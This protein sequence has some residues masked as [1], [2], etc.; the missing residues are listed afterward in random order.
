MPNLSLSSPPSPEFDCPPILF[1]AM[2]IVSCASG[3]I[4]PKLIAAD[5]NLLKIS[6]FGSTSEISIDFFPDFKSKKSRIYLSP[7][8]FTMFLSV[9]KS[10]FFPLRATA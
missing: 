6:S 10:S 3:E 4:E 7:R 1:I 5:A 2:A 8:P 9:S